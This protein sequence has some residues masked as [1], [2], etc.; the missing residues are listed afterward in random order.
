MDWSRI[1]T[2]V[3]LTRVMASGLQLAT[4]LIF[5]AMGETIAERA[6]VLNVGL[7]GI[8]LLSGFAGFSAAIS[9]QSLWMGV[10]A[11]VL[12][13]ALLGLLFAFMVV[14]LQSD[15]I[16]T[17]LALLIGCTGWA[18][19]LYNFQFHGR[20][21]QQIRPFQILAIP[22]LSKIP[23][24]G[25]VLFE[26]NILTYIMLLLVPISAWILYYTRFGLRINAVGEQPAAADTMGVKVRSTRYVCIIIG[27]ALAGLGGAYFPLADLG[28]YANTMVGGRGFIALA[29]VVFGRWNPFLALAGGVLFG[30]IDSLQIRLQFLGAPLPPQFLIMMPYVLT[31][32]VLFIGKGRQA[33]SALTQP[34]SRE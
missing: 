30:V 7:E 6:G 16:V 4:P 22:G 33:P 34:Y 23:F 31:I 24:L 11:G 3:F 13:G 25:P 27:C 32:L 17:G 10:A 19:Y 26:H 15:Q 21:L 8:M 2:F 29:L 28:C 14:T 12:T 5:T 20:C 1:L 18:M 9:T